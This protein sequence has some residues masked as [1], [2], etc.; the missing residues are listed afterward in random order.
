M[1]TKSELFLRLLFQHGVDEF[2]DVG[3]DLLCALRGGVD[4]VGLDV[5]LDAVDVLQEEGQQ[6]DVILF[7]EHGIHAV[8]VRDVVA[9]V[10]RGEGDAGERD[11]CAAV[12]EL[13]D[14]GGEILLR[15]FD[16]KA[17]EAVVAAELEDDDLGFLGEDAVDA[18]DAVFGGVAA[19]ACVDDAV[20]I[21]V[22][23]EGRWR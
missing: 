19:D 3:G 4:A 15:A 18:F 8:E 22:G 23:V 7:G 9:A 16:G 14:H 6:R 10:L 1:T 17:A 2:F 13:L 20:V 5:A 21:T 11:L 12:L